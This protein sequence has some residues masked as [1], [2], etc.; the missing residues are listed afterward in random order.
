MINLFKLM[1][2]ITLAFFS[3]NASAYAYMDKGAKGDYW[4]G[5]S[6]KD[7]EEVTKKKVK[8]QLSNKSYECSGW[9]CEGDHEY[10]P[11]LISSGDKK[12]FWKKLKKAHTRLGDKYDF[13]KYKHNKADNGHNIPE[14]GIVGLLAIGLLGVVASRI[15]KV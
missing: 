9:L 4:A 8:R 3:V 11:K 12:D 5:S 13:S 1:L 14:P 10:K 15:F 6:L 7:S 2:A